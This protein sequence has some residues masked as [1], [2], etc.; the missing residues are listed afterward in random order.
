[1][2]YNITYKNIRNWYVRL[3]PEGNLNITIPYFLRFSTKFKDSLIAK[4]KKLLQKHS[5]S[6]P[7]Q[8]QNSDWVMIFGEMI[9]YSDL[10][11]WDLKIYLRQTME[12]YVRPLLD[13]YSRLIWY[14]YNKLFIRK[15]RSKRWSCT[16]DQNIS[17]S[18]NLVHLPTKFIKYV[19]IHEVCHLQHK[20]H[21]K[22]FRDLV[23]NHCPNYK[24]IKKEISNFKFD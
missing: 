5:K 14:R 2:E 15:T 4:W 21:K 7:I 24:T 23:A 16:S 6:S 3:S 19:V 20:H 1:M 13:G 22:S 11:S 17:L 18:L 8:T 10:P 9:P 12:E